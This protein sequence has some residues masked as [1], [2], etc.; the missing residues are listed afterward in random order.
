MG[1][2]RVM[3]DSATEE[4]TTKKTSGP[5]ADRGAPPPRLAK[6][7]LKNVEYPRITKHEAVGQKTRITLAIGREKGVVPGITGYIPHLNSSRFTIETADERTSTAIVDW[8]YGQV[9]EF[10]TALVG[11]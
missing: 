4:K 9:K 5:V 1:E 11:R 6:R 3:G 2:D 10:G 7:Y 8:P